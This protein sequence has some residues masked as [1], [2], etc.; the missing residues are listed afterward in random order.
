MR[1][2]RGNNTCG[3]TNYVVFPVVWVFFLEL[4]SLSGLNCA[5]VKSLTVKNIDFHCTWIKATA[6][7]WSKFIDIYKQNHETES[8]QRNHMLIG[9]NKTRD[10]AKF[11]RTNYELCLDLSF[12]L[13]DQ[14]SFIETKNLDI[15]YFNNW[16]SVESVDSSDMNFVYF[17][18]SS[19]IE[20]LSFIYKNSLRS[21]K[22]FEMSVC[23]FLQLKILI[24]GEGW[25]DNL[26]VSRSWIVRVLVIGIKQ[27]IF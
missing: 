22:G 8:W 19:F 18:R 4:F 11:L 27:R 24:F 17:K 25:C 16:L 5:P 26:Q 3:I 14:Q 20:S 6:L 12:I 9:E 23:G 21:N 7:V 15:D 2:K 13:E 1:L 10:A